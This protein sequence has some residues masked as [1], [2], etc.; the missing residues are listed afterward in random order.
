MGWSDENWLHE[1]RGRKL[2]LRLGALIFVTR[3]GIHGKVWETKSLKKPTRVEN[4]CKRITKDFIFCV[5][6]NG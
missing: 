4:R 2:L 6:H 1:R 3:V 5:G